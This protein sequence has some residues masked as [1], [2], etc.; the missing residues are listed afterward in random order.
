MT[1]NKHHA[2]RAATTMQFYKTY[3]LGEDGPVC[4]DTVTDLLTDLRH[5]CSQN[6]VI[7][8]RLTGL[9]ANHWF[10]EETKP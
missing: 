9:S 1:D 6:N 4:E 8:E 5:W 3:G 10:E 7:F 2:N